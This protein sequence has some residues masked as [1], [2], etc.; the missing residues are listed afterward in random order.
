[1][2]QGRCMAVLVA[3]VI[4]A[5][6]CE[7]QDHSTPWNL[8]MK[9][10]DYK[11]WAAT[12][13]FLTGQTLRKLNSNRSIHMISISYFFLGTLFLEFK[14]ESGHS[15]LALATQEAYNNCDLSNPVK[16]FTEPNPIVTLGAP[17]KKFYVCGVGNHCNAGMKVI[18]NVVSSADAAAPPAEPPQK[19]AA[20]NLVSSSAFVVALGAVAA[21]AAVL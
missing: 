3:F 17:G 15:L 16:T 8:S 11:A 14:Y 13:T 9:K 7:A 20:G 12:Q 10:E 19:G 4:F 1:M 21:A 5:A 2:A 18:I 6:V